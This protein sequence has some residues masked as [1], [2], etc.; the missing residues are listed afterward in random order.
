MQAEIH[1]KWKN[2]LS[3]LSSE[4]KIFI[5]SVGLNPYNPKMYVTQACAH[6]KIE[7]RIAVACNTIQIHNL[8]FGMTMK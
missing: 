4:N 6:V 2:M 7:T 3:P 1:T 8:R 5:H